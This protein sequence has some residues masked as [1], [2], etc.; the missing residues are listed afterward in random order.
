MERMPLRQSDSGLAAAAQE[1][2][3]VV[4]AEALRIS[5]AVVAVGDPL[6]DLEEL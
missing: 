6:A 4:V 5:P 1:E 2:V 3:V